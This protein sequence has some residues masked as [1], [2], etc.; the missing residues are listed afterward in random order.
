MKYLKQLLLL[1]SVSFITVYQSCDDAGVL[2][3][4]DVTFS[5]T[6]MKRLSPQADGLYEAFMSF[7]SSGG[8]NDNAYISMGKFNIEL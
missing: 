5:Q 2:P 1:I 3:T 4:Y 7:N 6:N 8:H